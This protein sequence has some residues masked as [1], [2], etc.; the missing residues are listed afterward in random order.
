MLRDVQCVLRQ[1]LH[2]LLRLF[3]RLRLYL[4]RIVR[5]RVRRRLLVELH[6]LLRALLHFD[7]LRVQRK[8]SGFLCARLR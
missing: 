3:V 5:L 7:L 2:G 8:L 4:R 1:Q 6:H